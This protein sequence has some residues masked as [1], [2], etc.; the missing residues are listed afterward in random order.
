MSTARRPSGPRVPSV[1]EIALVTFG[2]SLAF[3]IVGV[4]IVTSAEN[5]IAR[6]MGLVLVVVASVVIILT[7]AMMDRRR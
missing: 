7:L 1:H 4:A 5:E 3:A 6:Q 2:L